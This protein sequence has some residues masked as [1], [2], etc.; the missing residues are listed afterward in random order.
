M[1]SYIVSGL[2]RAG[3]A[4]QNVCNFNY[5]KYF[6]NKEIGKFDQIWRKIRHLIRSQSIGHY[7]QIFAKI[8]NFGL[9]AR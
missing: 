8:K 7:G 2:N 9:Q 3:G 5:F 6:E 1:K 4:D